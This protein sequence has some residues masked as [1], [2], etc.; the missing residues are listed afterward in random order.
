VTRADFIV[1]LEQALRE[2][3]DQQR[4]ALRRRGEL[5]EALRRLRS[6]ETVALVRAR[7]ERVAG[8]E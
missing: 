4:A 2:V 5:E 3:K 8:L 1:E 6:G 7:L